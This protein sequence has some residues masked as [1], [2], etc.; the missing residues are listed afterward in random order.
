M[1]EK[2]TMHLPTQ[3]TRGKVEVLHLPQLLQIL[4]L[5]QL[6]HL[7]KFCTFV[8]HFRLKQIRDHIG[9][10]TYIMLNILDLKNNRYA[11]QR[12]SLVAKSHCRNFWR[13]P[14]IILFLVR[15]NI[16]YWIA[17]GVD[18]AYLIYIQIALPISFLFLCYFLHLWKKQTTFRS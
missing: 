18:R 3:L 12:I 11:L 4:H 10:C 6:L 14:Q 9:F 13:N 2:S 16:L 1:A 5:L 17:I 15:N 7:N 8:F